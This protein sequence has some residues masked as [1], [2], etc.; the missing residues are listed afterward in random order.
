MFIAVHSHF[1][2]ISPSIAQPFIQPTM[3]VMRY[4]EYLKGVYQRRPCGDQWSLVVSERYIALTTVEKSKDFPAIKEDICTI[5]MMH[6]E[7]EEVKRL[8]RT[9]HIGQVSLFH[10]IHK[11]S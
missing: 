8:K 5:A 11:P 3:H 1:N 9:I 6:S 4:A 7:I 10:D 2:Y